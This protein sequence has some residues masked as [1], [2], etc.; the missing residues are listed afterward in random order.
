M[1]PAAT[2]EYSRELATGCARWARGR[3]DFGASRRPP[4]GGAPPSTPAD[5]VEGVEV[6]RRLHDGAAAAGVGDGERGA[7]TAAGSHLSVPS[8]GSTRRR[9]RRWRREVAQGAADAG[10]AAAHVEAARKLRSSGRSDGRRGQR[11]GAAAADDDESRG[12][13]GRRPRVG[14]VR[15]PQR[16]AADP[17]RPRDAADLVAPTIGSGARGRAAHPALQHRNEFRSPSSPKSGH[18]RRSASTRAKPSAL[19]AAI[20]SECV[21]FCRLR[22]SVHRPTRPSGR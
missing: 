16:A 20:R 18:S 12:A 1:Q 7:R 10:A 9:R 4:V 8:G 2:A 15:R 14:V 22:R 19:S 3:S 17:R 6:R 5:A 21:E 11:K 13:V